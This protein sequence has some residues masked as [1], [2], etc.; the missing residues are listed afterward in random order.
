MGAIIDVEDMFV[1]F[2]GGVDHDLTPGRIATQ[3]DIAKYSVA[4]GAAFAE[5]TPVGEILLVLAIG[6]VAAYG[7]SELASA[8]FDFFLDERPDIVIVCRASSVPSE[9]SSRCI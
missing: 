1:G 3:S 9:D 4:A 2:G 6:G 8:G 5:P 7:T